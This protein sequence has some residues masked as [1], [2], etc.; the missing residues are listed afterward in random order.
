MK[1]SIVE[2]EFEYKGF[3]C[4]VKLQALGHRCGYVQL[5]Q[6][7]IIDT[8]EIDVHGGIT[9]KG[10]LFSENDY[11]IGWDYAHCCDGKD[12]AA[13][14]EKF[15]DEDNTKQILM[16]KDIDEEFPLGERH[17]YTLAEV[18]EDCR[19]VVNQLIRF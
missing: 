4:C 3:N 2:K 8:D 10:T 11:W 12:Y 13:V 9:Y 6:R 18:M 5:P 14:I 16:I 7:K 1:R 19:S 17:V 15:D